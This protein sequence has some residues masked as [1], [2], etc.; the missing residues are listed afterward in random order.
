MTSTRTAISDM[1]VANEFGDS[2]SVLLNQCTMG[3]PCAADLNM[4]GKLNFFDVP[5]FLTAFGSQDL[6]ADFNG[7]GVQLL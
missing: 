1:A 5:A 6:D 7:D 4:D 2:V 3:N